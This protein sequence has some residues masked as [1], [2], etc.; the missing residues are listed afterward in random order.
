M[1]KLR[2]RRRPESFDAI[3]FTGDNLDEINA[4]TAPLEFVRRV[5]DSGTVFL[6]CPQDGNN[7]AQVGDFVTSG[8]K[9]VSCWSRE[10]LFNAFEPVGLRPRGEGA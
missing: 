8:R 5:S 10:S 3:E 4:M 6:E 9:G 1:A 2:M 7:F